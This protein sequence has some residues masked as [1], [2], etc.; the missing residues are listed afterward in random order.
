[1]RRLASSGLRARTASAAAAVNTKTAS[2]I[3]PFIRWCAEPSNG[4]VTS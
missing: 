2:R 4:T 1:M 3:T